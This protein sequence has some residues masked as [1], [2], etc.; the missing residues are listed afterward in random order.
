[1]GTVSL[2][3][4][5]PRNFWSKLVGDESAAPDSNA[6]E[7]AKIDNGRLTMLE[8]QLN[9]GNLKV[10]RDRKPTLKI[11]RTATIL[12]RGVQTEE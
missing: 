9:N 1:M 7:P 10:K 2:N 6:I 12:K 5:N 8:R 4:N 11:E 3:L